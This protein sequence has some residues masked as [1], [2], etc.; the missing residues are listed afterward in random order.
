MIGDI[1][2]DIGNL[3][4]LKDMTTQKQIIFKR[5]DA[6]RLAKYLYRVLGKV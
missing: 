4:G 6:V 5:E 1:K 3:V 2:V